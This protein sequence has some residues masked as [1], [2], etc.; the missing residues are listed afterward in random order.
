MKITRPSRTASFALAQLALVAGAT[1][2]PQ[3]TSFSTEVTPSLGDDVGVDDVAIT[4]DG[5]YAVY[6]DVAIQTNTRIVDLASGE[7]VLELQSG[8]GPDCPGPG[9]IPCSGPCNDALEVTN[10]RAISLGQQVKIID[11]TAQPPVEI[12]SLDCGI[13]PRDVALSDDGSTAII[14]GGRGISGGTYVV[15]MNTG[16]ILLF[17]PSEP[18]AVGQQLGSDLAAADD[19]HGVTLAWDG[20]NVETDV[21]VVEFDPAGG[22]GPQVVLDTA[23]TAG[24]LGDPMDVAMSPDGQFATVRTSEQVAVFRLD[25]TNTALVRTF[26]SFPG[27][28]LPFGTTT[29]DTIVSTNTLWATITIADGV[30]SDGYL[31]IQNIQTGQNW[32]AFLDGSPRDL[33]LTPDNESLLVHTGQ[34]IYRFNLANLPGSPALN[35]T[36]F[37]PFPASAAGILA[38]IDSVA[39]T[40]ERAV[41]MAPVG[42]NDTRVRIYDLTQGVT[43]NFVFGTVLS[44]RPVDVDIAVDGSYA[45]LVTQ[46]S[47]MIFDL[48]TGEER[49]RVERTFP[50]AGWPWSDGAAIHPKHAVAGGHKDPAFVSWF[51][52]IDLVSREDLSCNSLPNST[53]V[54][55]DLFALGSSR[56][57]ENDL[58]LN[59]RFLPPNAA[60]LFFLASGTNSVPLGGGIICIGGTVLRLPI[61]FASAEGAVSYD[62]DLTALPPAGA[63]IVAG[64]TWY[65]QLAHRDLPSAGAFNYTNASSILFE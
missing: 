33:L 49:L 19:F 25:G 46:Q 24:F 27:G 54:T 12:A 38:G 17:S 42:T 15:D 2:A 22:G 34:K 41:V 48:R 32:F 21:L 51:D 55:G 8:L 36:T 53:G 20:G 50:F 58:T 39:A 44:G 16:S 4:P 7:Y 43:P 60:G 64:T 45:M 11:L 18:R 29:T 28:T 65:T 3:Y 52:T 59:A 26:D 10:E 23:A 57:D 9:S 31:N 35:T 61:V 6:R 63:G 13:W 47:Y 56:V 14:R 5:R 30:T 40:N 37:R 62:L 1:A